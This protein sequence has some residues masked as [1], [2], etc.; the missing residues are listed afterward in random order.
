MTN[1]KLY[2]PYVTEKTSLLIEN[3]K[4]VF[5]LSNKLN[6]IELKKYFESEFE[7]NINK[8]N[9]LKRVSKKVRRARSVGF[10]RSFL[11]IIITLSDNKN[12]EN[13]KKLF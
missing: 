5:L 2:K 10:K 9:V 7:I 11:K 3:N 6:K 13:L 8:V 1:Q 12:I 4:F